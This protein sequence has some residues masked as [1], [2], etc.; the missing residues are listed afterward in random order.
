MTC[1]G[2]SDATIICNLIACEWVKIICCEYG[3]D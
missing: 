2:G 3:T 1:E